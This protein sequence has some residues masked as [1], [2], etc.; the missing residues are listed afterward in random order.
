MFC[1]DT[2]QIVLST[3][4]AYLENVWPSLLLSKCLMGLTDQ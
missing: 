4:R 3:E 1:L 2:G